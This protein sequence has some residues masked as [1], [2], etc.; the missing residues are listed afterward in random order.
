MK[1]LFKNLFLFLISVSFILTSCSKPGDLPRPDNENPIVD[2]VDVLHLIENK[3][4]V[5]QG[6]SLFHI[7]N[8]YWY[9]HDILSIL[10]PFHGAL[11]PLDTIERGVTSWEF[12]NGEFFL[13]GIKYGTYG[14]YQGTI[15]VTPD[16]GFHKSIT[17]I[18]F[19]ENGN[20]LEI[21]I[22][23][24]GITQGR[25]YNKLVFSVDGNPLGN[26][27]PTIPNN[28]TEYQGVISLT[29]VINELENT[30]WEIV[31]YFF[32]NNPS[33]IQYPNDVI[34]FGISGDYTFNTINNSSYKYN[35]V[36]IVGN[37]LSDLNI[38]NFTLFGGRNCLL[39]V[40]Q[41]DIVNGN[42]INVSFVDIFDNSYKGKITLQKF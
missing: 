11:F 30:Q 24:I 26:P 5:L 10:D 36:N 9:N 22:N 33:S 27:N 19:S 13:N 39:K 14:E 35:L 3:V 21:K 23:E 42:L 29:T 34:S 28:S 16:N 15:G 7:D 2:D 17:N 8:K 4:W 38:Y 40:N 32:D 25:P 41:S 6:S 20:R 18:N 31:S 37:P 1:I 12:I